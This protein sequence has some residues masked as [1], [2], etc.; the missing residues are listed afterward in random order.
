MIPNPINQIR[1]ADA[2]RAALVSEAIQERR[3]S[4]ASARPSRRRRNSG[5]RTRALLHIPRI[6]FSGKPLKRLRLI[7]WSNRALTP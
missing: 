4:Q 3:L 1:D 5:S 7:R 6:T 2:H